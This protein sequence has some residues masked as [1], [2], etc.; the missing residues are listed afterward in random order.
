MPIDIEVIADPKRFLDRATLFVR[1][2]G[3]T[4]WRAADLDL[5]AKSGPG[6]DHRI[7]LPRLDAQKP[8]SVELYLRAYDAKGNEVLAWADPVRPREIALR[9]EPPTP[10]YRK[11]W[12]ITIAA[13]AVA[14]GTG[15]TVYELTI[16][17]PDTVDG[18]V[19][20]K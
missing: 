20:V 17:P 16:K 4:S 2:H 11:W 9:Y 6:T 15:I 7:V 14:I 10:W 12:V 8:L 5:H 19:M 13:S 1:T 3:E 18:G